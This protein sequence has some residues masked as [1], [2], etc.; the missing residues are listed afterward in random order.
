MPSK[1]PAR[2]FQDILDNIR[3]IEQYT[4]GMKKK[5]FIANNLVIDAVERCLSRISE[6]AKKL[7]TSAETLAPDQ[8]WA[9]IRGLGNLLRHE[10]DS[11][12]RSI[13]WEI[14]S[15]DLPSLRAACTKAIKAL[16]HKGS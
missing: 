15:E 4:S 5:A 6:A 14:V 10:Y 12:R 11:I 9:K 8:P 13:L 2:R 1:R 3:S 7:G 16:E